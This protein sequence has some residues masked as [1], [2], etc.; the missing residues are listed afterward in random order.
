ML[1]FQPQWVSLDSEFGDGSPSRRPLLPG[2]PPVTTGSSGGR[3]RRGR[4]IS[5]LGHVLNPNKSN[6]R[7]RIPDMD[8]EEAG[9]HEA[10]FKRDD[11]DA[12]SDR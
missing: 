5:L 10:E 2:T 9:N 4:R 8:D 12:D 7:L 11:S 1:P 6:L 3:G